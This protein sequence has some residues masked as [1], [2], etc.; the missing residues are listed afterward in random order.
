MEFIE[1]ER[2]SETKY[3]TEK[4]LW[5]AIVIGGLLS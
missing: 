2:V 1:S 5:W 4:H 3:K